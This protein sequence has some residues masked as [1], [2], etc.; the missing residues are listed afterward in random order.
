[1]ASQ[2]HNRVKF[3]QGQLDYLERQYPEMIGDARTPEAEYRFRAGQR[4][5]IEAVRK[6]TNREPHQE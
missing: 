1:M 5:V 3:S 2:P 4:S 6:L